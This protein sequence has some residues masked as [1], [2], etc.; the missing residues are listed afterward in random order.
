MKWT[1]RALTNNGTNTNWGF[2]TKIQF[3][4]NRTMLTNKINRA[5]E[6]FT[7]KKS[8]LCIQCREEQWA[9]TSRPSEVVKRGGQWGIILRERSLPEE[10]RQFGSVRDRGSPASAVS[11]LTD[12]CSHEK[13][14]NKGHA[15]LMM[16]THSLGRSQPPAA[17]NHI[18]YTD[19]KGRK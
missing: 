7:A 15:P 9:L 17:R 19:H 12:I 10:N 1:H 5:G 8:K 14:L 18:V 11:A 2:I 13:R 4:S 16:E 6:T 3:F